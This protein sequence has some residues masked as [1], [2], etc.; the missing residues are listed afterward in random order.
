[1]YVCITHRC[2]L[3][4]TDSCWGIILLDQ[5]GT[6]IFGEWLPFSHLCAVSGAVRA[7]PGCW[8][9]SGPAA[10]LGGGRTAGRD[11]PNG[12]CL[13]HPKYDLGETIRPFIE[14]R[15]F[16]WHIWVI[17]GILLYYHQAQ[18]VDTLS[19]DVGVFKNAAPLVGSPGNMDHCILGSILEPTPISGNAFVVI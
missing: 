13:R 3:L 16:E 19:L 18:N 10:P 12:P 17:S 7:D 4:C 6:S 1:M 5:Y 2:T 11:I 9:G 14:V 8:P 15:A